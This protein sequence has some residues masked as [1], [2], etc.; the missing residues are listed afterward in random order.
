MG[1]DGKTLEICQLIYMLRWSHGQKAC[2]VTTQDKQEVKLHR[3][4]KPPLCS[5]TF[6]KN[7]NFAFTF[8]NLNLC[9]MDSGVRC[10]YI[11]KS[12]IHLILT[13]KDTRT[14]LDFIFLT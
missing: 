7:P 2:R 6:L 13:S 4:W 8:N 12:W 11:S 14:Q 5:S 10:W 3:L 1:N 9:Y